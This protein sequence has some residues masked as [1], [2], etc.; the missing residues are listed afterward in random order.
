ME[1]VVLQNNLVHKVVYAHPKIIR[2][3]GKKAKTNLIVGLDLELI[4]VFNQAT[5]IY[6]P[7]W[8]HAE[9]FFLSFF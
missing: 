5:S 1:I 3:F 6:G 8:S 2:C 7:S 4:L 9:V